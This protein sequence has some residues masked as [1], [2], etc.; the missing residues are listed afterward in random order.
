MSA[1]RLTNQTF[2]DRL[3]IARRTVAGWHADP[4]L[5]PRME[6]QQLLD[7]LLSRLSL[8]ELDRFHGCLST[9]AD[10]GAATSG[11]EALR[12][13]ITIVAGDQGVLV[14]RRRTDSLASV[15]HA[16]LGDA[17]LGT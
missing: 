5:M 6:M 11:S 17:A 10:G 3:G 2:A 12:A 9:G 4:E 7:E 1:L 15:F 13:A 8:A 16:D 14:V